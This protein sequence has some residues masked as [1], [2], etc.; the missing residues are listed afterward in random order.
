LTNGS[1]I[2]GNQQEDIM[3]KQQRTLISFV[4]F[5]LLC[6]LNCRTALAQLPPDNVAGDWTNYSRNIDD[7]VMVTK[8]VQIA[9]NGTQLSGYFRGPNQAGGITGHVDIH[10]IE[11]STETR[12]VLT[13]RG[14]I[15]GN[16][17]SGMYGLHGRHAEWSAVR[18]AFQKPSRSI[19]LRPPRLPRWLHPRRTN[20]IRLSHPSRFIR[21]TS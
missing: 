10:H 16:S 2:T 19:A 5:E 7:G 11:F 9:Q 3:N 17:I 18:E 13:F 14:V 4:V 15:N 21:T 6:L 20:S 8:F 1:S 12:N